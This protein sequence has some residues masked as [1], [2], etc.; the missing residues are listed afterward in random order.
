MR[1]QV[2]HLT[3]YEYAEPVSLS[4]HMVHLSPRA[5][6]GQICIRRELTISP[7][8][9]FRRDRLDPFGNRGTYFSI[10]EP[11]RRLSV[12]ASFEVTVPPPS[13]PP[14]LFPA[15]WEQI[16]DRLATERR[17]DVVEAYGYTFDSPHVRASAALAAYAAPSFPP[18]RPFLEAVMDLTMRIHDQFTYD[19]RATTIAT[20]LAE[21]LE[22]RRGVCQDFA[23]LQI[24][25]LRSLGLPGRYV[26]GYLLTRPPPGRPRLVGADA[27][28]A[29]LSVNLPDFGWVD[30]DPTNGVMP[31]DQ[32]VIVACGRDFADVTPV[33]GVIL[34]GGAHELV[35]SVDVTADEDADG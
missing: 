11:H 17:A 2:R 10:E 4:H 26:S 24:G 22:A 23:H 12:D 25:C 9:S 32:H 27:S 7:T 34:G 5:D 1:Y 30:F 14:L 35:V 13:R 3:E 19:T 20:P 21:V 6:N 28:H 18:G 31:T 15:S 33:R 8:P 29:W 16:R